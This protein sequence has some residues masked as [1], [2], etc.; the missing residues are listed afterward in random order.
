MVTE[1]ATEPVP[2]AMVL[3]QLES[4]LAQASAPQ[5]HAM[6]VRGL[7]VLLPGA[8]PGAAMRVEMVQPRNPSSVDAG[9]HRPRSSPHLKLLENKGSFG[10]SLRLPERPLQ[11]GC[12]K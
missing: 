1:M 7:V 5:G 12:L 8:V 2:M 11:K 3:P 10:Y 6:R 4:L 9:R